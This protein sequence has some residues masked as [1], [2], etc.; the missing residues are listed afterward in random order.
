MPVRSLN[1]LD[2]SVRSLNG[3]SDRIDYTVSLPLTMNSDYNIKLSNL[4]SYGSANQILKMNSAG[5]ALEFTN[6]TDT[7]HTAQ[8]PI[9]IINGVIGLNG[10]AGYGNTIGQRQLIRTNANNTALEYFP[11]PDFIT[12]VQC[13]LA[14]S[15]SGVISLSTLNGLGSANQILKVNSAGNALEYTNQQDISGFITASSTTTFTNKSMSYSQLS[16]P[17]IS[18]D[19]LSNTKLIQFRNSGSPARAIEFS[20]SAGAYRHTV[21]HT[22]NGLQFYAGNSSTGINLTQIINIS[23]SGL[24][25]QRIE[26]IENTD[27][28]NVLM[29]NSATGL[30]A[31]SRSTYIMPSSSGTLA[32]TSDIPN[33]QVDSPLTIANN[34]ITLSDLDGFGQAGQVLRVNSGNNGLEYNYE[35]VR[36][37]TAPLV[38]DSNGD[39]SLTGGTVT[40]SSTT[41]FTNKSMSYSQ[42]TSRPFDIFYNVSIAVALYQFLLPQVGS[43]CL[44]FSNSSYTF[45]HGISHTNTS[46]DFFMSNTNDGI[47]GI[48]KV[49]SIGLTSIKPSVDISL[50]AVGNSTGVSQI[51]KFNNDTF[52]TIGCDF[53][54]EVANVGGMEIKGYA[55]IENI[56]TRTDTTKNMRTILASNAFQVLKGNLTTDKTLLLLRDAGN[57]YLGNV[58]NNLIIDGYDIS[59]GSAS[60]VMTLRSATLEYYYYNTVNI[61][62]TA[63]IYDNKYEL[64]AQNLRCSGELN[65]RNNDFLGRISMCDGPIYYRDGYKTGN[66]TFANDTNHYSQYSTSPIDGIRHQGWNGVALG[67]TNGGPGTALYTSGAGVF[68]GNGSAVSSDDRIKFNE[69]KITYNALETIN[70]LVVVEYDKKYNSD[71]PETQYGEEME[72]HLLNDTP[73][74]EYGY[75]AQD[76]YNN[77]PEL[78]FTIK[79]VDTTIPEN[80]NEEGKLIED[81]KIRNTNSEG[82]EYIDRKYLSIDYANINVLNVRAVQELSEIVKQQQIIIDKLINSTSFANFKK[83]I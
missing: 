63:K 57:N 70:K 65:M 11:Q 5:N 35:T 58:G 61:I 73:V 46:L 72:N 45:R 53:N 83:N 10:I 41:T 82:V 49:L 64:Q 6:E 7:V 32:L 14:I 76:T 13:P 15:S 69:T 20:N 19:G 47:N 4:T 34:T 56:I 60:G 26:M 44:M 50:L 43:N 18:N 39:I 31:K 23:T 80:F 52:N 48:N 33:I 78:R 81:C 37:A 62:F 27:S 77:I 42:I 8:T 30:I 79:N 22:N 24:K 51:I 67:Y 59:I 74:K 29:F 25:I 16:T 68:F 36:T 17:P 12:S 66:N 75:I 1:G 71:L 38:I 28:F 9:V 55:A 21:E 2:S 54:T 40:A 3:L